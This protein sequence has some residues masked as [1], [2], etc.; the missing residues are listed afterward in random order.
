MRTAPGVVGYFDFHGL[1][2][3]AQELTAAAAAGFVIG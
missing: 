1:T 2:M 3:I